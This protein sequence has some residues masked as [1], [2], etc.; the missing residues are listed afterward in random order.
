MHQNLE[1]ME[2][3]KQ[4]TPLRGRPAT[5]EEEAWLA[6]RR[7][8]EQETPKRLEEAAKYL[9]G[10]ISIAFTIFLTRDEAVFRQTETANQVGAACWLWLASLLLTFLVIFPFP[11]R[12][13]S[14]S[15][16]DIERVHRRSV[17]L[18]YGLL[19][20]GAALFL[21]ALGLLAGVYGR[22]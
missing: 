16:A 2:H 12:Q 6:F 4:P 15:A 22:S 8:A 9:S 17:R 21:L 18:K 20:A 14:R 7:Q 3:Q 10:M 1:F 13:S 11:W 5:P 19:V